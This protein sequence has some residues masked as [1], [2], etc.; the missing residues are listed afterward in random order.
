MPE[1]I[2]NESGTD[3]L[4]RMEAKIEMDPVAGRRDTQ[5]GDGGDFLMRARSLIE[6][7][8]LSPERPTSSDQGSHEKAAFI[9]KHQIRLSTRGFF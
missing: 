8:G 5:S 4:I 1:K 3:I 9:Q 7:R 2:E 6:N